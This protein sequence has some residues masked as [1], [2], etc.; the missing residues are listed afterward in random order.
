MGDDRIGPEVR[1]IA[2]V[3]I[4][5]VGAAGVVLSFFPDQTAQLFAWT[6]RP[7]M[8]AL[9][10]GAGYGSGVYFFAMTL[11]ATR[12]HRVTLGF[13]SLTVFAWYMLL[14]TVFHWE[15]FNH[16]SPVFEA[17][18]ILYVLTPIALP[19]V[20]F[21][22]REA[23][24]GE[25]EFDGDLMPCP[26]RLALVLVGL[27]VA[28]L[29]VATF[30]APAAI[31]STWPW[32]LT[33]LTARVVSAFQALTGSTLIL[34]ARDGRWSAAR[35]LSTALILALGLNLA[36]LPRAWGNF[37]PSNSLRFLYVGGLGFGLVALLFLYGTME[38]RRRSESAHE[39]GPHAALP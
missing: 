21:L 23:D 34:M 31:A 6:I 12:W 39:H 29:S 18:V 2:W 22:Y 8:T 16:G 11:T 17:W 35:T 28:F 14:A 37:D 32:Q 19:A 36:A 33:P 24:P 3:L 15:R 38:L 20:W 1:L 25:A 4:V 26:A 13:Q 30:V 7:R 9:F 27:A 5:T 10:M